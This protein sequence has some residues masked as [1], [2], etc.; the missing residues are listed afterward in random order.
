MKKTHFGIILILVISIVSCNEKK[1]TELNNRISELEIQN[2]K[3]TDSISKMDFE[4]V[5]NSNIIGFTAVSEPRVN[6][7]CE[8]KF[9]FNY[10][11]KLPTYN[12]YS[13]T[14]N[15]EP[16]ELIYS[17]LNDNEFKHKFIPKKTG[18][19]NIKLVA[20]F[21]LNNAEN[22]EIHIPTNLFVE[23]KK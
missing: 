10:S 9:I 5:L 3:L 18:E 4:K 16:D 21:K 12:V 20:V 15:G 2:K 14:E 11:E 6:E 23:I 19:Y 17:N 7:E 13:T 1:I 22:E 8:V